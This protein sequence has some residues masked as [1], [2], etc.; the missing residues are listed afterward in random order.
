MSRVQPMPHL[1]HEEL[2]ERFRLGRDGR[3]KARWQALWLL[4]RPEQPLSTSQ[5]DQR[6]G[7]TADAIRK[8]VH[9]YNQGGP[10]AVERNAGG[11]GAAPRLSPAQQE[12]FRAELL[13]RA[14]DSGLWSGPND[15]D[16]PPQP[17]PSALP[18][19]T[20]LALFLI[21][22]AAGLGAWMRRRRSE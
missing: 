20:S 11:H 21:S 14:P 12:Q 15:P 13:G 9:R 8:L 18:E 22:G 17:S 1:A 10:A 3:Q 7:L 19:P 4:A 2:A 6:V 5:A 16:P